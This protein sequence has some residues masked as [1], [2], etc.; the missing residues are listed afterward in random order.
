MAITVLGWS[1]PKLQIADKR[2]GY[3]GMCCTCTELLVEF[4]RHN[5]ATYHEAMTDP[6]Y[7]NLLLQT[8]APQIQGVSEA[9]PADSLP[10]A[11]HE[12]QPS[13]MQPNMQ[14]TLQQALILALRLLE[15]AQHVKHTFG[16]LVQNSH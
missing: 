11:E 6:A 1:Q 14:Q 3:R 8:K 12:G 16:R 13:M 9:A 4:K 7:Q 10:R 15:E 5:V 2:C